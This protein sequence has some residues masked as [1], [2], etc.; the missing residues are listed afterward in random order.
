MKEVKICALTVL[1]S[2]HCS[3]RDFIPK[4]GFAALWLSLPTDKSKRL[5]FAGPTGKG[6]EEVSYELKIDNRSDELQ[7]ST[8]RIR[9]GLST[10]TSDKNVVASGVPA[11]FQHV[12]YSNLLTAPYEPKL[13]PTALQVTPA[14][15]SNCRSTLVFCNQLVQHYVESLH[16]NP[17][18]HFSIA[19][20]AEK[21]NAASRTSVPHSGRSRIKACAYY[22]TNFAPGKGLVTLG[23]WTLS[24]KI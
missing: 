3:Q 22:L 17:K 18:A 11:Y 4:F 24:H 1:C 7:R 15:G 23:P 5:I 21:W 13:P 6:I 20:P 19:C 9:V 10:H 14:A 2:W 16:E 8:S 12:P